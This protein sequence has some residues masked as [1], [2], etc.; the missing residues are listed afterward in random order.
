MIVQGPG[1]GE[2]LVVGTN[3]NSRLKSP[4]R[5]HKQQVNYMYKEENNV[6]HASCIKGLNLVQGGRSRQSEKKA[7]NERGAWCIVNMIRVSSSDESMMGCDVLCCDVV[8]W[9]MEGGVLACGTARADKSCAACRV[10]SMEGPPYKIVLRIGLLALF[11]F[12]LRPGRDI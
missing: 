10:P 12:E 4:L 11:R 9:P 3:S 7:E 8:L 5:F 6:V 1:L 2:A